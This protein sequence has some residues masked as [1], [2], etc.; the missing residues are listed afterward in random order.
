[1]LRLPLMLL[2][3]LVGFVACVAQASEPSQSAGPDTT[4][5]ADDPVTW[6]SP[7]V[8][9]PPAYPAAALAKGLSAVVDAT[10]NLKATGRLDS[11]VSIQSEPKDAAFESAVEAVLKHWRFA[12]SLDASC[13][14]IAA[15]SRVRI[16]FEIKDGKP[17]V[18]VTHVPK[19]PPPGAA[20]LKSINRSELLALIHET[21]PR[22]AR[23]ARK[24]ADVYAKLTVDRKSGETRQVDIVTMAADPR[25]FDKPFGSAMM[26]ERP[27]PIGIQYGAAATA[28]LRKARFSPGA[29][30]GEGLVNVCFKVSYRVS[31]ES[32]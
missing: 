24:P 12:Q 17:S 18:S 10:L 7:E 15:Q 14:P 26:R 16:W 30:G 2:S 11:I 4:Y 29:V 32:E 25:I 13:R 19:A 5:F 23:S 3:V 6:A 8:V 20:A 1:M 27:V 28:A 21:F 31:D 22:D 9:L